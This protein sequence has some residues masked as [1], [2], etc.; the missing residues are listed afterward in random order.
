MMMSI[1]CSMSDSQVGSVPMLGRYMDTLSGCRGAEGPVCVCV[2]VC[3]CVERCVWG[4]SGQQTPESICPVL[5]YWQP[6]SIRFSVLSLL[7]LMEAFT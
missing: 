4:V 1:K 6:L 5:C 3:V 7:S 2:C